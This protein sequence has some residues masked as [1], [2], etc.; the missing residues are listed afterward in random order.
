VA[1]A[2]GGVSITPPYKTIVMMTN[3]TGITRNLRM[4]NWI[5]GGIIETP[6]QFYPQMESQYI[7]D[8][9]V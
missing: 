6:Y 1:L 8:F 9:Q 4:M 2:S 7:G 5:R 3:E